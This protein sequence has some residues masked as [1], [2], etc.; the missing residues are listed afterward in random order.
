MRGLLLALALGGQRISAMFMMRGMKGRGLQRM[1]KMITGTSDS[2]EYVRLAA[3][4]ERIIIMIELGSPDWA[5]AGACT[6]FL[7]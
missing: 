6:E 3:T 2:C 4:E 1:N 7:Q 5:G